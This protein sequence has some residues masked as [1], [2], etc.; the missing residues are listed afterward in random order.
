MTTA[1]VAAP[2]TAITDIA[3]LSLRIAQG[4]PFAERLDISAL[5]LQLDD[6]ADVIKQA[7]KKAFARRRETR[8]YQGM[9]ASMFRMFV[10]SETIRHKFK[11]KYN[12]DFSEGDYDGSDSRN[13]FI[14]GPLTG[15][16]GTCVTMPVL[17]VSLGRRLGYPLKLVFAKHHVVCRW[18]SSQER[19]N[20][21]TTCPGF[22]CPSDADLTKRPEPMTAEDLATGRFLRSLSLRQEV[23]FIFGER[24]NVCFDNFLADEAAEAFHCAF[25]TLSE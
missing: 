12:L 8:S 4:L 20:I 19:F 24:G 23:A 6:W 9:T 17:F 1:V 3:D 21:E 15:H 18:D 16:G 13:H 2:S 11:V 25:S 22:K 10:L 5:L 14:H 7:T